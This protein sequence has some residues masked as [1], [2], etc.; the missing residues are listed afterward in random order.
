MFDLGGLINGVVSGIS[1]AIINI[2]NVI[3]NMVVSL[4][5]WLLQQI[6]QLPIWPGPDAGVE[7]GLVMARLIDDIHAWQY[8]INLGLALALVPIILTAE[9]ALVAWNVFRKLIAF[10]PFLNGAAPGDTSDGGATGLEE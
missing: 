9:I 7:L 8:Y 4:V 10:I 1:S 6:P 5:S 2:T 3:V